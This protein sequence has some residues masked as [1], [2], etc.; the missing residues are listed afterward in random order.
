MRDAY[1]MDPEERA[2]E[3]EILRVTSL[4]RTERRQN[5]YGQCIC[6]LWDGP[7]C[8][9][10]GEH[11]IPKCVHPPFREWLDVDH[12]RLYGRRGRDASKMAVWFP[13]HWGE[14]YA[15]KLG[16]LRESVALLF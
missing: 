16:V 15:A 3:K 9:A 1:N 2:W 10:W 12:L 5:I 11:R 6:A 7:R 4:R 13:Y 8:S 14:D